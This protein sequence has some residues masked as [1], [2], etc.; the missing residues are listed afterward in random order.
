MVEIF[1]V[2]YEELYQT[3]QHKRDVGDPGERPQESQGKGVPEF[4]EKEIARALK[5]LKKGKAADKNGMVAEMLKDGGAKLRRI[6]LKLINDVVKPEAQAP[7]IWYENVFKVLFKGGDEKEAK[8]YR[9]IC[10]LP[11]LHKLFSTMVYQRLQPMLDKELT[12]EQAGFRKGFATIDHLYAFTQIQDKA[13]E[14][15]VELWTCF[16]DYQKAFDSVEHEAIWT[17]LGRQGVHLAYIDMLKK[18]YKGQTGQI[19]MERQSSRSFE[20][21][22]GTKQGDPLST[23]LSNAVLEDAFREVRQQ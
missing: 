19:K 14:R 4:N 11:I 23:L 8:N 20:I 9:P 16:L 7:K 6:L 15:Q 5:A 21:Q 22:R 18:M 12:K 17:A 13:S 1:A 10:V 3:R 2:F